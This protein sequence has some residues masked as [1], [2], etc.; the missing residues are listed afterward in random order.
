MKVLLD[1]KPILEKASR[2]S[3]HSV[4]EL[5]WISNPAAAEGIAANCL[6]ALDPKKKK[7]LPW[8]LSRRLRIGANRLPSSRVDNTET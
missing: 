3:E 5:E 1:V 4:R 8:K 2:R 6:V 7:R